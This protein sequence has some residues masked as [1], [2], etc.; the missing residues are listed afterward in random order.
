MD[1]EVREVVTKWGFQHILDSI[2]DI[3][4]FYRTIPTPMVDEQLWQ[5][6]YTRIYNYIEMLKPNNDTTF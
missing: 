3:F 4:L 6:N 5:W 2:G 1:A